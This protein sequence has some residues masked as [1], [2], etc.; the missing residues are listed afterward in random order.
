MILLEALA[1]LE[2]ISLEELDLTVSRLPISI[3]SYSIFVR[4]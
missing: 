4:V 2:N 1:K 3:L